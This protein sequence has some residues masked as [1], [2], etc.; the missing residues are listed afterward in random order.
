MTALNRPLTDICTR[1]TASDTRT[2]PP[3]LK[4]DQA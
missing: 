2:A 3:Q 1:P 4:E